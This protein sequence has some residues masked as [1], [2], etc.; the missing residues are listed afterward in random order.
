MTKVLGISWQEYDTL[1][2]QIPPGEDLDDK[3]P[4]AVQLNAAHIKEETLADGN[5]VIVFVKYVL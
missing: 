4:L 5:E 3:D 1:R 2:A